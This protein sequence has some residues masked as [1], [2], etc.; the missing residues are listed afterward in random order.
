MATPPLKVP[1][2][3]DVVPSSKVTVPVGMPEPGELAVTVAV[4]VTAWPKIE[5]FCEELSVVAVL[6][7]L[8]TWLTVFE[9]LV[10]KLVSPP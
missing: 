7:W 3:R 5:G 6:S 8:T 10:V 4:N 9:V 2:P 1:V